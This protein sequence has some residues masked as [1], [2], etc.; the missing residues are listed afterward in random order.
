M[1]SDGNMIEAKADAL[2]GKKG[3][4]GSK[5][6][7]KC[8]VEHASYTTLQTLAGVNKKTCIE[9]ICREIGASIVKPLVVE[10]Q[11]LYKLKINDMAEEIK[12]LNNELTGTE[13]SAPRNEAEERYKLSLEHLESYAL[14]QAKGKKQYTKC[15]KRVARQS[16]KIFSTKS[17][18]EGESEDEATIEKISKE[19]MEMLKAMKE[20]CKGIKDKLQDTKR[21]FYEKVSNG[22]YSTDTKNQDKTM[23]PRGI[24]NMKKKEFVVKIT[25][26]LECRPEL[27]SFVM[28][29]AKRSMEDLSKKTGVH[30]NPSTWDEMDEN[31]REKFRQH[32]GKL[33]KCFEMN[34]N[35]TEFTASKAQ[36]SYGLS[37]LEKT[38][39][40]CEEGNGLRILHYW[41]SHLSKVSTASIEEVETDLQCLPL[42]FGL[43]GINK[44]KEAVA[45]A[46]QLLEKGEEMD[47]TVQYKTVLQICQVLCKKNSLFVSIHEKYLRPSVV[48][49]RRNSIA[50]LRMLMGDVKEVCEKI[51]GGSGDDT[52]SVKVNLTMR[53][54]SVCGLTGGGGNESFNNGG[55]GYENKN[56]S[57][58]Q[59]QYR[60]SETKRRRDEEGGMKQQMNPHAFSAQESPVCRHAKCEERAFR[61]KKEHGGNVHESGMCFD[62]FVEAVREGKKEK[63]GGVPLKGGK[64][65]VLRRGEDKKWK[66]QILSIAVIDGDAGMAG[67]NVRQKTFLKEAS[68]GSIQE[69]LNDIE[70]ETKREENEATHAFSAV[71]GKKSDREQQKEFEKMIVEYEGGF[72]MEDLGS[73]RETKI[74]DILRAQNGGD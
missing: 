50:D 32:N 69:I 42:L 59:V 46:E 14:Q 21:A 12:K 57:T 6:L 11:E 72:D 40:K 35:S 39:G 33:F 29:E 48:A 1:G 36:Y 74:Y 56:T 10:I 47:C 8:A 15:E 58:G 23:F 19:D 3:K 9:N 66:F 67:R 71:L 49:E 44:V 60:A 55:G 5:A 20:H 26:Y 27:F 22:S 34:S 73:E 18:D 37:G 70:R 61:H 45:T 51:S 2:V 41:L 13:E 28:A 63:P 16:E 65:M 68:N 54:F 62:H 25:Q 31:V 52:K 30:Y 38:K 4:Y 53:A 43:G 7:V 64:T 17:E 24:T